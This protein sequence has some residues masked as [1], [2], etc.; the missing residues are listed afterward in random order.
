MWEIHSS[1]F[2]RIGD[3]I[4]NEIEKVYFFIHLQNEPNFS[5]MSGYMIDKLNNVCGLN[6]RRPE[7]QKKET[8]YVSTHFLNQATTILYNLFQFTPSSCVSRTMKVL[9]HFPI[10]NS[11]RSGKF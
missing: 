6:I 4:D 7:T 10:S 1:D 3:W 2:T 11:S 9:L 5:E 8:F